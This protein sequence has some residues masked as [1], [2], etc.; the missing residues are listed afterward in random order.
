MKDKVEEKETLEEEVDED[1]D[2]EVEELLEEDAEFDFRLKNFLANQRKDV[3][4]ETLV[5]IPSGSLEELFPR[6]RKIP[7]ESEEKINYL[8]SNQSEEQKY[9]NFSPDAHF[10]K[11]NLSSE[12]AVLEKQ[13]ML[14]D[15]VV[16][17][18]PSL[19]KEKSEWG[20]VTPEDTMQ[21]DYL[22]KKKFE[23]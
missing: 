16:S 19:R 8:N 5:E 20:T 6:Q 11:D 14:Y 7:E 22:M 3:A 18:N 4:L 23:E 12:E 21:K 9:V 17:R 13:K 10:A 15:N 1:N 2:E